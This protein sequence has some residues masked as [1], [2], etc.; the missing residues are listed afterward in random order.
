MCRCLLNC[1]LE[2]LLTIFRGVYIQKLGADEPF[3][4]SFY[5]HKFHGQQ[6]NDIVLIYT[7]TGDGRGPR[8]NLDPKTACIARMYVAFHYDDDALDKGVAGEEAVGED[9]EDEIAADAAPTLG[10]DPVAVVEQD[11]PDAH[12][13]EEEDE[14]AWL[15]AAEPEVVNARRKR[16]RKRVTIRDLLEMAA[17]AWLTRSGLQRSRT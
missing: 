15:Q 9:E 10:P 12:M 17:F 8:V 11:F 2:E 5:A 13:H 14:D 4:T 3:E 16:E 1:G 7:D 6:R